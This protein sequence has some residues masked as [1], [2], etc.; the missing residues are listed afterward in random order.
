M[1]ES[2]ERLWFIFFLLTDNP[3]LKIGRSQN[4]F[5]FFF[6]FLCFH[7]GWLAS[8]V[9]QPEVPASTT[10]FFLSLFRRCARHIFISFSNFQN[11]S[12]FLCFCLNPPLPKRRALLGLE[13]SFC[14]NCSVTFFSYSVFF[15]G[16]ADLRVERCR[17]Y[18][19][20]AFLSFFLF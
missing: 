1:V 2:N 3:Y 9:G 19:R 7:P 16:F 6:F 10:V 15:C 17:M 18:S 4:I 5:F 8:Y 20:N 14:F 13:A 11:F 12:L